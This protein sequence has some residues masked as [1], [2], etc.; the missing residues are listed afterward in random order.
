MK[1]YLDTNIL[2]QLN[3]IPYENNIELLCSQLGIMELISG[4]TSENE[5]HIR[6]TLSST[7]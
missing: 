7:S 5:Y 2:R 1:A 6:K 4:M 3:K